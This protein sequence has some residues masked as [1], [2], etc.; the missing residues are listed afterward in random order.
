MNP[1]KSVLTLFCTAAAV[2][3]SLVT[4]SAQNLVTNGGF[5]TGD[6]TGWTLVEP[7]GFSNVGGDPTFAH[8]GNF[9]A[10][11]APDVGQTG[12]LSQVLSTTAG[13]AYVLTFWL[14][15]N[16]T[17]PTNFFQAYINGMLVTA[18]TSPPFNSTGVY[19][20]LF[21]S[22]VATGASTTLEFRY[23]NDQDFWRLDDVS[24]SVP[25]G[26]ATLWVALPLFAGLCLL[27][28][29]IRRVGAAV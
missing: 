2:A 25:E 21:A 5:E 16:T 1:P 23:R 20:Q 9:H 18:S 4:S 27:H 7:N 15:N 11:L 14:A 12:S 28:A 24:V 17:V 22:F 3:L 8:S 29:R 10:N 6:F 26:G 19:Q 13:T